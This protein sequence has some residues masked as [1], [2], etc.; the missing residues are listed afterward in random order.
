MVKEF[1]VS[2][3]WQEID[4]KD[5]REIN[6]GYGYWEGHSQGAAIAG[7]M[8]WSGVKVL[9]D[10]IKTGIKNTLDHCAC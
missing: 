2:P 3:E 6:G 4:K 5:L 8:F 10:G 1:S 7:K 9:V